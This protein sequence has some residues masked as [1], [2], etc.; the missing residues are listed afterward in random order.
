MLIDLRDRV[1]V[2]S[3]ASQGIGRAI[4]ERF[5]AEGCRVFGLD[6]RFRDPLPEGITAI[7]ADVTD[8][9]SVQ[10]AVAQVVAEAGR[11]DVLV[12]NAG[13]NV[14]GSV[15]T[16][17]PARFQAAFDVNVGGVF[18]LSQAVIPAMKAAGGG[19]IINA[20]SFAAVIP[21]VGAAAYGASNAAVVQFTR[22]LASELGPWGITVNAYAPGM[23]P[24][25]MNGFAEMPE[26]AQDR[27]LDTLSIRRW[28]RPDDVADLLLF[29]ASDRA[30]YITGTLVDVS[31]GKLATQMPQRAYEGAG[32]PERG[33]R[34]GA[35][36]ADPR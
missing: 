23:I 17:E 15:E 31:G 27:L 14:E 4:A 21:S 36:S 32:A 12:N 13:I 9:A 10:A 33:P 35:A 28:E 19:R 26:P 20:A 1:V 11:V 24:T 6:L 16:L 3:G 7:V 30:G 29:L 25:T 5:L 22:V 2:V 34:D 18:L 8:P